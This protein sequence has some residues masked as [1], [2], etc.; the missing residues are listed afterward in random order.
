MH[1]SKAQPAVNPA[2]VELQQIIPQPADFG[3]FVDPFH[4]LPGGFP[5]VAAIPASRVEQCR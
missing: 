5:T 3:P 4:P 2:E 1:I